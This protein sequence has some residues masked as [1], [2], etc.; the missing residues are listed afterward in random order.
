[1]N[2]SQS[3]FWKHNKLIVT[4]AGGFVGSTVCNT[5]YKQGINTLALVKSLSSAQ[6]CEPSIHRQE[7]NLLDCKAISE[8]NF[9]GSVVVHTASLDGGS[10]FKEANPD[11]I[12]Y[13]NTVMLGNLFV[14]FKTNPPKVFVY[15]SSAEIYRGV[16]KPDASIKESDFKIF[17]PESSR[18][19]YSWSKVVGESMVGLLKQKTKIRTLIIRPANLYGVGDSISKQRLVSRI[20]DYLQNPNNNPTFM[21]Q[22]DVKTFM[23]VEDFAKNLLSLI[24]NQAEGIYNIAG[25]NAINI[26]DWVNKFFQISGKKFSFVDSGLQPTSFILNTDKAKGIIANWSERSYDEGIRLVL[27]DIFGC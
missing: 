2:N 14:A 26:K 10:E 13:E 4:G 21:I 22:N 6:R 25:S 15:I 3:N 27:T 8:I 16:N 9:D 12:F 24:E 19:W 23:Y 17:M 20:I 1:M 7:V 18:D 11:R 5:A